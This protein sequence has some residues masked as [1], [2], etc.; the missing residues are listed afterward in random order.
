MKSFPFS[1]TL[2]AVL[3][4]LAAASAFAAAADFSVDV[5]QPV[6]LYAGNSTNFSATISNNGADDWFSIA[7][8]GTYTSWVSVSK[9]GLFIPSGSNASFSI[10]ISPPA[11]A[12]PNNY[13]YTMIVSR[14]GN[15]AM[16]QK[17]FFVNVLQSSAVIISGSSLSCS[18]CNPGDSVTVSVA[19]KNIGS[20]AL[21]NMKLVFSFGDRT[22]TMSVSSL[23]FGAEKAF[24][25]D[26]SL[27]PL[28][29]PGDYNMDVKLVQDTSVLV[30]KSL[31]FKVPL[32]SN[33]KTARNVSSSIFGNYITLVSTNYGNAPKTADISSQVLNAWYS[34][35]SG[36]QPSSAGA[37]YAWTVSLAPGESL[38]MNYSEIFW[39][40]PLL[41]VMLAF[42][43]AYYYISATSLS[44]RKRIM[45]GHILSEGNEASVSLEVRSGLRAI[46]NVVVRDF[47]PKQF[48]VSERFETIKPVIRKTP[49]GTELVWRLGRLK[50]RE[51]RVLHYR[52][53]AV[54]AFD[55][56]RLQPADLNGRRGNN[57]VT[58][59]SGFVVLHGAS[60]PAKRIK[61]VVGK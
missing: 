4:M 57:L 55:S 1:L 35:Y 26:F 28:A 22:K 43:G 14:A 12:F 48:S 51:V 31:P 29:A 56:V 19:L 30:R 9:Q 20:R 8:I 37:E 16:Q 47:V 38:T 58:R 5:T 6:T 59:T 17:E 36:P 7:A 25:T 54:S 21:S 13:R 3:A 15:G 18:A 39:P 41:L 32:I 42:I 34:L 33:I 49:S 2:A 53:K 60:E 27:D 10:S 50:S 45:R 44:L 61:V 40:V 52:M 11:D 24:S 23:D 46:D